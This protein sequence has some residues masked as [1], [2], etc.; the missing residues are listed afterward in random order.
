MGFKSSRTASR[1]PLRYASDGFSNYDILRYGL[2]TEHVCG[3]LFR[4]TVLQKC[5]EYVP[6]GSRAGDR[7]NKNLLF[8]IGLVLGTPAGDRTTKMTE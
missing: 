3:L 1:R 2:F 4:M 5:Q 8:G 6:Y 7:P